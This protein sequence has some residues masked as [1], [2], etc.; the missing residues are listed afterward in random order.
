MGVLFSSIF[1]RLFGQKDVRILILG[2]DN[3]GKTTILYQLQTGEVVQTVPTIGFNVET[4]EYKNLKFQVWDLGGQTTIR[5]YWRCY[6]PNTNGIIYVVDSAD[7]ERLEDSRQELTLM[8]QEEELKGVCLVI[9]ANKQ[10]LPGAMTVEQLTDG[11]GLT[12]LRG[13]QWAIF[14]TSA[15]KGSGVNDGLDWLANV[16]SSK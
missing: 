4:V 16:I 8:L 10:D 3:A 6:Y 15:V 11:L 12:E 9:F 7:S 1:G 5:P 2:L 13:R 14:E